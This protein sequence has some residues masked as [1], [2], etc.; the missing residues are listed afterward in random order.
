MASVDNIGAATILAQR[1]MHLPTTTPRRD[2]RGLAPHHAPGPLVN[3]CHEDVPL[4]ALHYVE[5][6]DGAWVLRSRG[7]VGALCLGAKVGRPRPLPVLH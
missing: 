7:M 3:P 4:I 6:G 1:N 5:E 2:W